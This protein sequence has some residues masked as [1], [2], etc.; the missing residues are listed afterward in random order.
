MKKKF[1]LLIVCL[2]IIWSLPVLGEVIVI[3]SP[4][5]S[6]NTISGSLDDL[7]VGV[8]V[9]LGDRIYTPKRIEIADG[10]YYNGG[11]TVGKRWSNAKSE[12]L[13]VCL[14]I[15]ALNLST[16]TQ[17]YFANAHVVIVYEGERGT[18]KFGGDVEQCEEG[19]DSYVVDRT[20]I[21]SQYNWKKVGVL[22]RQNYLFK[23]CIPDFVYE[24]KGEIR[25]EIETGGATMV[26]VIRK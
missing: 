20:H 13:Y 4:D 18:Y 16:K 11:A 23:C 14:W 15:E 1:A 10:Y 12:T 19:T 21:N 6:S 24:N 8:E 2:L 25:M 22:S 26:C 9:D 17:D 3:E 5:T 7:Q